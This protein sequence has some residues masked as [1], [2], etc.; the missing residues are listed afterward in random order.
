LVARAV[1]YFFREAA[2]NLFRSWKISL[3]AVSAIAVSLFIGGGLLLLLGNL[4]RLV[5]DRRRGAEGS[6][7]L[8]PGAGPRARDVLSVELRRP[9]WVTG[10][11][12]VSASEARQRFVR[13][14]PSVADLMSGWGE[15]PLP[16][17]YEV[18]FDPQGVQRSAFDAWL[19]R[20]RA[21]PGVS[22]VDDDRDW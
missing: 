16:A 17:S 8:R 13:Y 2:S 5:A 12:V 3:V 18:S 10:L 11:A 14:F 4:Q 1:A 9:P 15:E 20:L 22:M 7:F 21:Q 19:R 6:V